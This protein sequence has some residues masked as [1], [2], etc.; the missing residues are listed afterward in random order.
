MKENPSGWIE[1]TESISNIAAN[2]WCFISFILNI[3]ISGQFFIKIPIIKNSDELWKY[4]LGVSAVWIASIIIVFYVYRATKNRQQVQILHC[5]QECLRAFKAEVCSLE[6]LQTIDPQSEIFLQFVREKAQNMCNCIEKVFRLAMHW[7]ASVCIKYISQYNKDD[8]F[9]E[10]TT[11]CRSVGTPENRLKNDSP[12]FASDN[13]DFSLIL[14]GVVPRFCTHNLKLTISAFNKRNISYKNSSNAYTSKYNTVIVLPI[15]KSDSAYSN[16]E[17]VAFLCVDS[18]KS[19]NRAK[20]KSI[21]R[22]ALIFAE[23]L[24]QFF[25]YCMKI[26]SLTAVVNFEPDFKINV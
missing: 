11:L 24:Y 13:T 26:Q 22:M 15:G 21:E 10:L 4:I 20:F 2:L 9:T 14:N 6:K 25:D 23:A 8:D 5:T 16:F 17:V 18:R 12:I 19:L 1:Q 7:N 3:L